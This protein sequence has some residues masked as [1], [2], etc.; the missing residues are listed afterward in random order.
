MNEAIK[1]HSPH[2]KNNIWRHGKYFIGGRL[3]RK[4]FKGPNYYSATEWYWGYHSRGKSVWKYFRHWRKNVV[5]FYHSDSTRC[6][7]T[8]GSKYRKPDAT[9]LWNEYECIHDF[10][11]VFVQISFLMP[12][13][14]G[15]PILHATDV[16]FAECKGKNV[17]CVEPHVDLRRNFDHTFTHTSNVSA[18]MSVRLLRYIRISCSKYWLLFLFEGWQRGN[19]FGVCLQCRIYT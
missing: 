7:N 10:S 1:I 6:C 17:L 9:F 2:P 15:R 13:K 4:H 3:R 5:A 14:D 11:F 12:S 18:F 8:D 19:Q 16:K